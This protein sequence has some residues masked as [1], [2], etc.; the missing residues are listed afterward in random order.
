[1]EKT[2]KHSGD[3]GDII[4]S[5]PIIKKL[6]GGILYLDI[7]GGEDE[8]IIQA[9]CLTKKTKFNQSA[10]DFIRPL[11]LEQSYIKDVRIYSSNI[12]IDYNLNQFR[13]KF[14]LNK[15]IL[16]CY[17]EA[18]NINY[19]INEP[20]LKVTNLPT[21][22]RNT[23]VCRSPRYQSAH[24]WFEGNKFNLRDKALF[25]GLSKEH[26]YFEWTF[27]IKIPYCPVNNALELAKVIA[28]SKAF[29]CNQTFALSIAI[30]LATIPIV[31]E[32]DKT[33]PNCVYS[34]KTNMQYI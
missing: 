8:P 34:D 21:L 20:W 31:Q 30:G 11:L 17:L 7:T 14:A 19:N 15:P 26:E 29:I 23:V 18:F 2:F 12:K 4:Y 13:F 16:N 24:V 32:V 10:Y 6:G 33:V 5:L 25:V 1:M 9:Q 28:A 22:P 3:L 27:D